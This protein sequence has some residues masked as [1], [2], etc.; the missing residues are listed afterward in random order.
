MRCLIY[1]CTMISLATSHCRGTVSTN[2]DR[3]LSKTAIGEQS[4]VGTSTHYP[5]YEA[6]TRIKTSSEY[7]SKMD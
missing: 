7:N 4:G 6:S 1:V 2:E 3:L 5:G